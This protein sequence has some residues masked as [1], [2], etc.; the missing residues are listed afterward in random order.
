MKDPEG[1]SPL[2]LAARNGHLEVVKLLREAGCYTDAHVTVPLQTAGQIAGRPNLDLVFGP[3]FWNDAPIMTH[4]PLTLAIAAGHEELAKYLID[5]TEIYDMHVKV[6][7]FWVPLLSAHSLA[8]LAQRQ[9]VFERLNEMR[10]FVGTPRYQL[11][12][13]QALFIA[14]THEGSHSMMSFIVSCRVFRF[15]ITR[16]TT[17]EECLDSREGTR[18]GMLSLRAAILARCPSNAL[19]ILQKWDFEPELFHVDQFLYVQMA[20]MLDLCLD[21]DKSKL[22]VVA[23][24]ILRCIPDT[25]APEWTFTGSD[26]LR[27]A[28]TAGVDPVDRKGCDHQVPRIADRDYWEYHGDFDLM[29]P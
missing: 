22:F 23:S 7:D 11:W 29:F 6:S 13:R 16:H 19:W 20:R 14:A 24:Q 28:V 9:S 8:V 17:L 15:S 12:G 21:D 4:N 18:L 25:V 3:P 27:W 5:Y 26:Y 2:L 10:P 1:Y